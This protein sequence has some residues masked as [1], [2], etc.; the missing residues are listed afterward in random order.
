MKARKI[1]KRTRFPFPDGQEFINQGG[2]KKTLRYRENGM[3]ALAD[4][5][6]VVYKISNKELMITYINHHNFKLPKIS[7]SESLTSALEAGSVLT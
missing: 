5:S 6:G 3:Y 4:K 7:D 1:I 2:H